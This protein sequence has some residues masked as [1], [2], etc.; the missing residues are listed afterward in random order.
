MFDFQGLVMSLSQNGQRT[1]PPMDVQRMGV[2]AGFDPLWDN[3]DGTSYPA[4][5]IFIAGDDIPTHGCRFS[6][7]LTPHIGDTVF[8]TQTGTDV[9]VT[10]SLSGNIKTLAT[11]LSAQGTAIVTTQTALGG[12]ISVVAHATLS[13]SA[14]IA[15]TPTAFTKLTKGT[16][17]APILPNRLYKAEVTA[18]YS[19][20]G[21]AYG[22]ALG[23]YTPVNGYMKIASSSA[24]GNQTVNGSIVASDVPTKPLSAGQ[25]KTKYPSNTFTWYLGVETSNSTSVT[26]SGKNNVQITIYEMGPAS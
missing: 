8:L 7:S 11:K 6:S 17:V 3:G 19:V 18:S 22:V 1:L 23:V 5:S 10:A 24:S 26:F 4:L 14:T 12:A 2:I 25:W 16:L 15:G 20:D 9:F 21:G 13:V